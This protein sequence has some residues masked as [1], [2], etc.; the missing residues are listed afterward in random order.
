VTEPSRAREI[1]EAAT[2]LFY[3]RGYHGTSMREIAAR[4]NMRAPSLYNHLESKQQLLVD[5]IEDDVALITREF[6][7]A[8]ATTDDVIEKF[9]RGFE[10][11]VRHHTRYAHESKIAMTE[12]AALEEP[13]Q[14]EVKEMRRHYTELWRTLIEQAVAE[15]RA[16]TQSTNLAAYAIIDMGIGIA[17]WFRP[18]GPLSEG[19]LAGTYCDFA[20]SVIGADSSPPRSRT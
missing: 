17:R 15:G 19:T 7:D 1:R 10:V 8:T 20:L 13:G 9:R 5:I 12:V 4:L 16:S 14:S 11:H 6:E 18:D 3:E 2:E